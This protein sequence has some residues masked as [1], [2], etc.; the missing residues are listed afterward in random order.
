MSKENEN[1]DKAQNGNDFIADVSNSTVL[2][3]PTMGKY[4]WYRST[5]FEGESGWIFEGGEDAYYEALKIWEA[6][7]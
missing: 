3:K 5:S 2:E 1:L 4:G 6:Q 7:Q